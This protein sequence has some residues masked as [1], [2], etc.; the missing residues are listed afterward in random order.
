MY[1]FS[2]DPK[3]CIK[4]CVTLLGA[5]YKIIHLMKSNRRGDIFMVA[6]AVINDSC[7][8]LARQMRWIP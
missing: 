2:C 1:A 3:I 4:I 5:R 7:G 6:P 8:R